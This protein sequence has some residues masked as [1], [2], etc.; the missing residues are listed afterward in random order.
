MLLIHRERVAPLEALCRYDSPDEMDFITSRVFIHL[1]SRSRPLPRYCNG[2]RSSTYACILGIGFESTSRQKGRGRRKEGRGRRGKRSPLL[3][4]TLLSVH[5]HLK[6][7]QPSNI[8]YHWDL[9]SSLS[10]YPTPP[11][12]HT[13]LNISSY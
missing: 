6:P 1:S 12:S 9:S 3:Y 7:E 13:Q 5:T 8:S 10:L 11:A 2:W 4:Q